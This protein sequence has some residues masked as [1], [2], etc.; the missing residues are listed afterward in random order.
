MKQRMQVSL[1][2]LLLVPFQLHGC[3]IKGTESDGLAIELC[4]WY[5][6]HF[7]IGLDLP[8]APQP[9]R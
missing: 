5:L 4:P 8:R 7:A 1:G 6:F 3:S 2:V 9:P